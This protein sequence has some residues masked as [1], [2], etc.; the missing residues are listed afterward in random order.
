MKFKL[1][2]LAF[3]LIISSFSCS[4]NDDSADSS[5]TK[6]SQGRYGGSSDEE[7]CSSTTTSD[8]GQIILARTFSNDGDALGNF[9]SYIGHV[10]IWIIKLNS[11]CK[12]EWKRTY[13]GSNSE[14]AFK[15]IQ[16]KDGEYL[17]SVETHS[18]DGD[19]LPIKTNSSLP[20]KNCLLVKINAL[21]AIKWQKIIDNFDN[22]L[23]IVETQDG[24]YLYNTYFSINKLDA[25]A[26]LVWTKSLDFYCYNI[27]QLPDE[28]LILSG[29]ISS[30]ESHNITGI[31]AKTDSNGNILW[32][33]SYEKTSP[34]KVILS[35]DGG[36]LAVGKT[37]NKSVPNY[38]EFANA[39]INAPL[40]DAWVCKLNLSGNS[41]WQKAFGETNGQETAENVVSTNN[42]FIIGGT[43]LNTVTGLTK[44]NESSDY[45]VF[46]I[47]NLGN[48]ITQKT[49]GGSGLD[50]LKNIS[51]GKNNNIYLSGFVDFDSK[52]G[53]LKNTNTHGE[54]NTDIWTLNVKIN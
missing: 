26:N 31:I 9:P 53:D 23:D 38:H 47:D 46:K 12:I 14:D 36:L 28:N 44:N 20:P 45:W 7:F 8:G 33:K 29:N 2:G 32:K 42:E 1:Y 6:I 34:S 48:L 19:F 16:T 43:A 50:V 54:F 4:N 15:I 24:G 51:L 18:T 25:D 35:N 30:Y 22:A 27:L 13:G 11:E 39:P 3:T 17:F 49:F 37:N 41:E 10:D 5:F 40:Y 21:G 52:D